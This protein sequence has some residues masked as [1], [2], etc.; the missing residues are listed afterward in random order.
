[1]VRIQELEYRVAARTL[2]GQLYEL[3]PIVVGLGW[4][5]GEKE[6]AA[7]ITM[8]LAWVDGLG[9]KILAF[10][11]I[12]IYAGGQ[13]VM[14]GYVH[15]WT[16][17]ET[18][19]DF[20]LNVEAIDEVQALRKNQDEF[21]FT[22]GHTTTAILEEIL[23]KWGVPHEIHLQEVTHSKK[24]Y[25]RKYLIDMIQDV[26]KDLKEKGGGVYFVRARAGVV[27]IIP[28]GTNETIYH[29]D[30]AENVTRSEESFDVS[31]IVTR[32]LVVAKSKGE[33]HQAIESTVDGKTEWGV[34]QI[35]YERGDKENLE[36]AQVAAQKIIDEQGAVRRTTTVE[37]PDI[38]SLR[39]GDRL[40]L[41]NS[42]GIGY[43]FVKS[44]THNAGT[45]KMRL[46]LDYDKEY[47]EA[48]G[49]PVYDINKS[50]ESSSSSPP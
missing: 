31:G 43:F 50:D 41:K 24:V 44:I 17:R 25:R 32:V 6:L 36:E 38:P 20:S 18:S 22:D 23:S 13:E 4:S 37:A 9:E 42:A 1:M 28:R 30:I 15:K 16:L 8:R 21:Y 46:T 5:E 33:G 14:R 2:D 26:L 29:F 12:F 7:K 49:L 40:R 3:T 27:E 45:Q 47:S 11:P 34:H 39:K 19:G 48:Q 35:I 10:T